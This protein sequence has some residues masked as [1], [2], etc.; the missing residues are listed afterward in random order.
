MKPLLGFSLLMILYS[1]AGTKRNYLERND[2]DKALRDAVKQLSK[3]PS[4]DNA[5]N[6]LPVL[7]AR[8]TQHHLLNIKS[9]ANEKDLS[10][11]EKIIAEYDAL[12]TAY[13]NIIT[14]PAAFKLV[15]PENYNTQLLDAKHSA[16]AA[17]YDYGQE[18]F[19]V[20]GRSNAKYAFIHFRNA[21][22]FIPEFRD[23]KI[24][25]NRS[26]ENSIVNV[27]INPVQDNSFFFNSGWGNTG[28]NYSNEYF[29]QTLVRELGKDNQR[30]PARFY[31]EWE[32]RRENIKPDWLVTL[33]LRNMDIPYPITNNYSRNTSAQVQVGTDTSGRPIYNNVYA[34]VNISRTGFTARGNMEV[35]IKDLATQKDISYRTFSDDYRWEEERAT[36]TGDSRALTGRDWQLINNQYYS[37]PRKEDVLN[38]LYKR[39]YPQVKNNIIYT[40]DW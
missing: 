40:V 1:C 16:A 22:K 15:T 21:E 33:S 7:Y 24:M 38:E 3:E 30:Y 6:A 18:M 37:T 8:I 17:H 14:S 36:Y 27:I 23:A 4:N 26:Y 19:S 39:I 5:K 34:T 13:E 11:W 20:P 32:A 10:R 25:M 28:Y 29:Q 35:L 31:T 2:A 12:Q 9:L